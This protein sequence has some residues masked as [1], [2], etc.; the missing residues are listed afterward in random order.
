MRLGSEIFGATTNPARTDDLLFL[1]QSFF[2]GRS[3]FS[4]SP[5]V[6][7]VLFSGKLEM[8]ALSL[9]QVADYK[10]R[11]QRIRQIATRYA[12]AP[13]RSSAELGRIATWITKNWDGAKQELMLQHLR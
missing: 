12:G 4:A 9:Q 6:S 1:Q 5:V 2:A 3:W 11:L 8:G 10:D 13:D 7:P